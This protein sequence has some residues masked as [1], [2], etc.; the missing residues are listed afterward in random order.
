MKFGP[1]RGRG[2]RWA[3][4]V[5]VLCSWMSMGV[6]SDCD[7]QI[8]G[9]VIITTGNAVADITAAL[10]EAGFASLVP[11]TPTPVVTTGT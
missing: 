7:P 11:E 10:I 3:L 2:F 5:L 9:P 1:L 6:L 8:A 4:L